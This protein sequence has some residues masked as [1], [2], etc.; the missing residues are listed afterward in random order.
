MFRLSNLRHNQLIEVEINV[1]LA[2]FEK[3]SKTRSFER[4]NLERDKVALFPT[5]WTIV[6]PITEESPF[7][8]LGPDE[9]PNLKAEVIILL[10]AFDDTFSQTIYSRTSFHSNEI[11]WGKKFKPMFHLKADGQTLLD[12]RLINEMESHEIPVL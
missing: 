3:D 12:L 9:I 1:T 2:Y 10:K 5:S 7:Y 8:G 6:H 4:L 11:L